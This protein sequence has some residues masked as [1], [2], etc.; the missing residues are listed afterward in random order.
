[1]IARRSGSARIKSLTQ[2]GFSS[3]ITSIVLDAEV[4]LTSRTGMEAEPDLLAVTDITELGVTM[5]CAIRRSDGTISVHAL[6]N[7]EGMTDT[8]TFPAGTVFNI[9]TTPGPFDSGPIPAIAEDCLVVVGELG[10]EYLRMI[11][12]EITPG[13]DLT[14]RLVLVDEAP[15]LWD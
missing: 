8:L 12:S 15:E 5:G 10:S 7:S 11:V 1:V 14:A 9:T 4:D 13:P 6:S 3:E 2:I